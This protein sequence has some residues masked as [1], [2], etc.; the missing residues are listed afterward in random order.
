MSDRQYIW[1]VTPVKGS[2][3]LKG[4]EVQVE[5]HCSGCYLPSVVQGFA[6]QQ[7]R[8]AGCTVPAEWV[9]MLVVK[10]PSLGFLVRASNL[11]RVNL[12]QRCSEDPGRGY[13]SVPAGTLVCCE[14]YA[15]LN[16]QLQHRVWVCGFAS[17]DAVLFS[18]RRTKQCLSMFVNR[19]PSRKSSCLLACI[20]SRK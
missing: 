5:K 8:S 2:Y 9:S 19:V 6:H 20:R 17:I 12:Q 14:R 3:L 15:V 11:P 4:G 16:E 1:Y 18:L 7:A 13:T 10:L